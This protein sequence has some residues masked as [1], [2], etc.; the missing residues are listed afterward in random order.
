MHMNKTIKVPLRCIGIL[1]EII[2]ESA[3]EIVPNTSVDKIKEK[4]RND[5]SALEKLQFAVSVNGKI[6]TGNIML[7]TTDV[8]L[9]IPPYSGG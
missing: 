2:K 6:E 5:Y 1:T 8:L 7:K 4:L 9:L 3:I